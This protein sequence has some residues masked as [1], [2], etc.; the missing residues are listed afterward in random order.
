[1]YKKHIKLHPAFPLQHA[2][3]CKRH[4]C[5]ATHAGASSWE[6]RAHCRD[7]QGVDLSFWEQYNELPFD[8]GVGA[9][10]TSVLTRPQPPPPVQAVPFKTIDVPGLLRFQVLLEQPLYKD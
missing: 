9:A 7:A 3:A 10:G 6:V 5:A 2:V 4:D 8:A 1:M